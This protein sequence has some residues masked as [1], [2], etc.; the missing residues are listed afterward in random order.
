ML[1]QPEDVAQAHYQQVLSHSNAYCHTEL[2][3]AA[4]AGPR[5]QVRWLDRGP[6]REEVLVSISTDGRV[7][8]W[9]ITKG[10]EFTD[11]MKLKRVVRRNA[12]GGGTAAAAAAAG[13]GTKPGAAGAAAAAQNKS[14]E[15]QEAFISR[16][17]S[18]MS[19]D[20]SSRDDRMYIAGAW[21]GA[22]GG[23][24]LAAAVPFC[25]PNGADSPLMCSGPPL[26]GGQAVGRSISSVV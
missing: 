18:G 22:P 16:L 8:Q 15:E 9:S 14:A 7:T 10:L 3:R 12:A 24:S 21:G 2:T 4:P 5:A 13:A 19:F 1:L 11:L 6:E 20:F 26:G 17:T 23:C 25:W